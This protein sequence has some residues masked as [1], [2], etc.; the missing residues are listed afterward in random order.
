VPVDSA[1]VGKFAQTVFP[2]DA[3]IVLF[4]TQ[5]FQCL[6]PQGG[7]RRFIFFQV[8]PVITPLF[9]DPITQLGVF[10]VVSWNSAVPHSFR[11]VGAG[12]GVDFGSDDG[13]ASTTGRYIHGD[14]RRKDRRTG[15]AGRNYT[16]RASTTG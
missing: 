8:Q 2:G 1:K 10:A 14:G 5:A 6:N 13:R 11:L 12:S 16:A 7:L 4:E 3:T 15:A 9:F